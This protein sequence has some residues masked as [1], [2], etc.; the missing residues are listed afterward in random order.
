[1]F[2]I[3][4]AKHLVDM[5]IHS[6]QQHSTSSPIGAA[7]LRQMLKVVVINVGMFGLNA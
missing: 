5:S 4:H 3:Q 7:G 6:Q 1:M 2:S